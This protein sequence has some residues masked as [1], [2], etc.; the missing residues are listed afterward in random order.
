MKVLLLLSGQR[1]GAHVK[2]TTMAKHLMDHK[3]REE[4]ILK[5]MRSDKMLETGDVT[6]KIAAKCSFLLRQQQLVSEVVVL[7][8]R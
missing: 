5:L 6:A 2:S 1:Q 7:D 3:R 4:G 8:W